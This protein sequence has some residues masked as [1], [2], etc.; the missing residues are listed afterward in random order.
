[1]DKLQFLVLIYVRDHFE[2]FVARTNRQTY[3]Y[4]QPTRPAALHGP[5]HTLAR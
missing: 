3:M 5:Y 4:I 2:F 1:M